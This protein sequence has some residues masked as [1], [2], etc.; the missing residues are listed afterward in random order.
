VVEPRP[1]LK[2][3]KLL[4]RRFSGIRDDVEVRWRG[5]VGEGYDGIVTSLRQCKDIQDEEDN[6]WCFAWTTNNGA[7]LVFIL[8]LVSVLIWRGWW[9]EEVE[10]GF[11]RMRLA[12]EAGT[13]GVCNENG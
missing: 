11:R 4:V 7:Y 1:L 8:V 10:E 6:Q 2:L 5:V 9:H 12:D 3:L 13:V